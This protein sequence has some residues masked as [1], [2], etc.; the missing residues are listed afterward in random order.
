MLRRILPSALAMLALAARLDA[1]PTAPFFVM[2]EP[3]QLDTSAAN[4]AKWDAFG[5]NPLTVERTIVPA[6]PGALCAAKATL[7]SG[8]TTYHAANLA[9]SVGTWNLTCLMRVATMPGAETVIA[10]FGSTGGTRAALLTLTPVDAT[11]FQLRAAHKSADKYTCNGSTANDALCA[12]VADP[13][14]A[15]IDRDTTVCLE[16][17]HCEARCE[18]QTFATATGTTGQ[19]MTWTLQQQNGT[20]AEVAVRLWA[21]AA[22]PPTAAY[23]Q[24]GGTRT[25]GL[26][27]GGTNASGPC[28]VASACPG[29]TCDASDKITVARVRLGKTDTGTGAGTIHFA[30]CFGYGGTTA[31]PNLRWDTLAP[32][33]DQ[34]AGNW[35]AFESGAGVRS[36]DDT[37]LYDCLADGNTPDGGSSAIEN[38]AAAQPTAAINYAAISTPTPNPTPLAIVAEVFGQQAEASAG[39][40]DLEF[41]A[42]GTTTTDFTDTDVDFDDQGTT[43]GF[44]SLPDLVSTNATILANLNAVALVFQ[45][46]AGTGSEK[47]RF[48]AAPISVIRQTADPAVI[49]SIPDRDGDG[50]QTVCHVGDSI[51]DNAVF[52]DTF[53]SAVAALNITNLYFCTKGGIT[54]LDAADDW[55]AILAGDATQFMACETVTRGI[56]GR[57]CDVVLVMTGVNAWHGANLA[58]PSNLTTVEGGL[59]QDGVCETATGVG[60]GQG[61]ACRCPF[62]PRQRTNTARGS[63]RYCLTKGTGAGALGAVCAQFSDCPCASNADCTFAGTTG[64]CGACVGGLDGGEYCTTGATCLSSVCDTDRCASG[65]FAQGNTCKIGHTSAGLPAF[66]DWCG[67]GCDDAPGC[68]GLCLQAPSLAAVTADY[69]TIA[70]T[71]LAYPSPVPTPPIAGRPI[72]VYVTEPSPQYATGTGAYDPGLACWRSLKH[73]LEGLNGWLRQWTAA[74]PT[75]RFIDAA[76]WI[77]RHCPVRNKVCSDESCCYSDPVHPNSYGQQQL[78][79]VLFRGLANLFGTHDGTCDTGICTSGKRGQACSEDVECDYYRANFSL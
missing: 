10:D 42:G 34:V 40:V 43:A 31:Y 13:E 37:H 45:R 33:S 3:C 68:D 36:C 20:D 2:G 19:W 5:T 56:G 32:I 23:A 21:G 4:G 7:V 38:A 57:T 17:N 47:M 27:A 1:A 24:G 67:M 75:H 64:R 18:R 49:A 54:P 79:T 71:T 28:A 35:D 70:A 76:A 12:P 52:Q 25:V 61:L 50:E 63:E 73:H 69:E 78:A 51:S 77:D 59:G 74:N 66:A 15:G 6:M 48:T 55:M 22:G 41:A 58:P 16:T 14:C 44:Y 30:K 46:P 26:C 53:T 9:S 65:G 8:Q 11:R 60:T 39:T 62:I 72:V 29:G